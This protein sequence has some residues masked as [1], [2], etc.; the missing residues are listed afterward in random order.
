MERLK[1]S[2][3]NEIKEDH[4]E[5]RSFVREISL[6]LRRRRSRDEEAISSLY[7]MVVNN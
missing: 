6:K 7:E 5:V 1:E 3:L 4:I 2:D